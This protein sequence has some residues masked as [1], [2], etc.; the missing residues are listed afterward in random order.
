MVPTIFGLGDVC[1][2]EIVRQV[3]I[4]TSRNSVM[5]CLEPRIILRMHNMTVG[6]GLWI[7]AQIRETF[8]VVER[9]PAETE[10]NA[11]GDKQ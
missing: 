4:R 8:G 7:R 3:T 6:A 2:R 1:I 10:Q 5:A 11:K 9:A